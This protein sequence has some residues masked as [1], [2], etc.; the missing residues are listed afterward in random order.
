MHMNYF[1]CL[2][3]LPKDVL[4]CVYNLCLL[5]QNVALLI[6]VK[7]L[8][9]ESN[10]KNG[11]KSA[12]RTNQ[13]LPFVKPDSMMSASFPAR[14]HLPPCTNN[15]QTFSGNQDYCSYSEVPM[16][17]CSKMS[18]FHIPYAEPPEVQHQSIVGSL[19]SI[20]CDEVGVALSDGNCRQ[21]QD[22]QTHDVWVKNGNIDLISVQTSCQPSSSAQRVLGE[23][24]KKYANQTADSVFSP[25]T[26]QLG[27][28]LLSKAMDH[29]ISSLQGAGCTSDSKRETTNSSVKMEV[30]ATPI[31][32]T[33][34]CLPNQNQIIRPKSGRAKTNAEL[35]RQ[36]MER[37]EQQRLR[38]QSA[39]GSTGPTIPQSSVV[40][41]TLCTSLKTQESI[42]TEKVAI[43]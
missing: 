1:T 27:A 4:R 19:C 26:S 33:V 40:E 24:T 2:L 42:V 6:L 11:W 43:I 20:K 41:P 10:C 22:Q 14:A 39:A 37:R 16:I 32:N 5:F 7:G 31:S 18:N 38:D 12:E 25:S 3:I 28:P 9:Y 34:I 15:T 21:R 23:A 30:T 8:M 13:A 17:S 29:E 35:K 36:L